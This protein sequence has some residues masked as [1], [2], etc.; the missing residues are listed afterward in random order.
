MSSLL[1]FLGITSIAWLNFYTFQVVH[2][3]DE[4]RA[5]LTFALVLIIDLLILMWWLDDY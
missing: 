1:I 3:L 4:V 5:F 2:E